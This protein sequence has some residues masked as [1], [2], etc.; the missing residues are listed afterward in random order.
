MNLQDKS[1]A[2][3]NMILGAYI[4]IFVNYSQTI[5][6]IQTLNLNWDQKLS[7][8]FYL[9]KTVSG[10]VQQV[11]ALECLMTGLIKI[12]YFA[13][14]F[15]LRFEIGSICKNFVSDLLSFWVL[16]SSNVVL[17]RLQIL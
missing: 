4:K 3:K 8:M 2:I 12:V 6:I 5:A 17:D 15:V 1:F 14:N 16:L 10:G 9:H 11:I 7:D 13:F